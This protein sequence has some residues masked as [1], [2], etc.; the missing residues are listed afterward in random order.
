[1]NTNATGP[2]FVKAMVSDEQSV[3]P[4]ELFRRVRELEEENLRLRVELSIA[5]GNLMALIP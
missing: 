5:R 4:G 3:T 2:E 1:M